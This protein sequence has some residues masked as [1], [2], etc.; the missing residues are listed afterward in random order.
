MSLW[1]TF[2]CK[3]PRVWYQK[4]STNVPKHKANPLR[5]YTSDRSLSSL[6]CPFL[7]NLIIF[8]LAHLLAP[9]MVTDDTWQRSLAQG[10]VDLQQFSVTDAWMIPESGEEKQLPEWIQRTLPWV[11]KQLC[12]HKWH[13]SIGRCVIPNQLISS[14]FFKY[15]EEIK[16]LL[17]DSH[18]SVH[19]DA[20]PFLRL[21]VCTAEV[22]DRASRATQSAAGSHQENQFVFWCWMCGNCWLSEVG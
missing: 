2:S 6:L 20:S 9:A 16:Y 18:Q 17:K 14:S 21:V 3:P 13:T 22:K 4:K 5:N 12:L 1:R 15:T 11:C 10:Y 7:S 19:P 8:A